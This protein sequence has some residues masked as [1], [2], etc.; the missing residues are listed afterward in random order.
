[1]YGDAFVLN[2]SRIMDGD[3]TAFDSDVR[4]YNIQ[5]TMLPTNSILARALDRSRAWKRVYADRV[6]TIHARRG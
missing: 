3:M 4:R 2:Y 1:M 5:W 6:G